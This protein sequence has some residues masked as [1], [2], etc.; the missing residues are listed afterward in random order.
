MIDVVVTNIG[1]CGRRGGLYG[2]N[3]LIV[4]D[5]PCDLDSSRDDQ[6]SL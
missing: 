5:Q 3:M 2:R 1:R 6:Y 4:A